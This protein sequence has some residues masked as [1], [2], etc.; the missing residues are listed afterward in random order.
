MPIGS[1]G[2]GP[3]R[4]VVSD[5]SSAGAGQR[6]AGEA[7]S[8]RRRPSRRSVTF[9]LGAIWLIDGILQLQPSM[10][11]RSFALGTLAGTAQGQPAWVAQS[12][13]GMA[14]F[15]AP[16]I[17]LWNVLFALIQ[18]AIGVCL[19]VNRVVRPALAVSIAWS[20]SVWWFG[21][22]FGGLFGGSASML[23]GAPGAVMLYALIA[24][25][26]WPRQGRP[27][28]GDPADRSGLVDSGGRL[29]WA[30]L[31]V[32]SG[33]LQLLSSNRPDGAISA[34]ISG[35][36]AGEPRL[37]AALAAAAARLVGTHGALVGIALAL[38]EV[39]V[40]IGA[41]RRRPDA[42]L[43]LGALLSLGF[44]VIGQDLGGILTGS[45]TDPNSGP[46]FVLL[47]V[48]LWQGV[49]SAALDRPRELRGH[50]SQHGVATAGTLGS[51]PT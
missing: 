46:L 18:L 42:A 28:A 45:G 26:V 9:L 17:A 37:L 7:P 36:A 49:P 8:F 1:G 50:V 43:A 48:A 21:E 40:G 33:V 4:A 44:W 29:L 3:D 24:V 5:S 20:F 39:A 11:S 12:V 27:D 16:H 13:T 32:G 51:R 25:L 41:L 38:V 10:F 23:T 6:P 15:L 19:L 22:A 47:A 31:W 30:A 34:L 14:R 35:A 2:G